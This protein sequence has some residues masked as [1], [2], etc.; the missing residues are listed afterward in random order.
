VTVLRT[1]LFALEN[2]FGAIVSIALGLYLLMNIPGKI[3]G[4]TNPANLARRIL[5]RPASKA[6]LQ[7]NPPIP[8][9]R[10][11]RPHDRCTTHAASTA[12]AVQTP[13]S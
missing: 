1:L 4:K 11:H 5:Q 13:R 7:S 6:A 10:V 12:A 9:G 3:I 2:H 8:R